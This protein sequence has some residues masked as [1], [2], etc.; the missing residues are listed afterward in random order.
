M[1]HAPPL[2]GTDTDKEK[3]RPDISPVDF[4]QDLIEPVPNGDLVVAQRCKDDQCTNIWKALHARQKRF[5]EQASNHMTATLE[6]VID[7]FASLVTRNGVHVTLRHVVHTSPK[8]CCVNEWIEES[9]SAKS[10]KGA[11][12]K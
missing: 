3:H 7:Q 10:E 6:S 4:F 11:T 12:K 9:Q 5:Y 1:N 8:P 2:H